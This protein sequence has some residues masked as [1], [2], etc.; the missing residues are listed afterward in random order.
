M[1]SSQ[2]GFTLKIPE[3]VSSMSSKLFISFAACAANGRLSRSLFIKR[4]MSLTSAV[5][6]V[7]IPVESKF[8]ENI[9][10]HE[11]TSC[12]LSLQPISI[13]VAPW[14]LFRYEIRLSWVKRRLSTP[15]SSSTV[16]RAHRESRQMTPMPMSRHLNHRAK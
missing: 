13:F 10:E 8:S 5:S 14:R 9:L 15:I 7:E 6:V 3:S 12:F 4:F 2:F 16:A 11:S 1:F